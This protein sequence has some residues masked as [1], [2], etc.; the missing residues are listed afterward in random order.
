M[1]QRGLDSA[2]IRYVRIDGTVN[3]PARQRTLDQFQRMEDIKVILMT[4]SC[5]GVGL[6]VTA[7]SRVH[8]LEP[9]WNPA[10]EDQA[11][12]RV[13]RMGQRK[14]VVTIRYIMRDSIEEV[15]VLLFSF[16]HSFL[17][18]KSRLFPLIHALI[19]SVLLL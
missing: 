3:A 18:P 14:P 13:H 7:A 2:K 8:L 9:Q 12:A 5:G 16:L 4:I 17:L 11:L 19:I 15:S 6:D 1:V 10:V